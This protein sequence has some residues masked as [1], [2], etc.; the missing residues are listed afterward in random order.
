MFCHFCFSLTHFFFCCERKQFLQ[1]SIIIIASLQETIILDCLTI[2]NIFISLT[3]WVTLIVEKTFFFIGENADCHLKL[4]D[5]EF[6]NSIF[7][8]FV[9]FFFF[10]LKKPIRADRRN[11]LCKQRTFYIIIKEKE[12]GETDRN[13]CC[14]SL[15]LNLDLRLGSLCLYQHTANR[16]NKKL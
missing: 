3:D 1:L 6:E 11:N 13:R 5:K 14:W 15:I 2:R 4:R 16:N 10:F 7:L 9:C 8:I 12:R